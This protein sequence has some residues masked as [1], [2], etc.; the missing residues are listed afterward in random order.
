MDSTLSDL[1]DI[2]LADYI[3]QLVNKTTNLQNELAQ[4]NFTFQQVN[5]EIKN[6]LNHHEQ[7][8]TSGQNS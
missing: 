8:K 3:V 5:E 7:S 4:N 2:Q 1:T 6:R